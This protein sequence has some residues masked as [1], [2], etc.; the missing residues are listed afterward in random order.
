MTGPQAGD[1]RGWFAQFAAGADVPQA[2]RADLDR[3]AAAAIAAITELRD[4]LAAD[5][6]PRTDGQ[7]DG[8][9][10]ERYRV[11]AR[12]YTGADLD[13]ADAYAYG[14]SQYRELSASMLSEARKIVPERRRGA[15][16]VRVPRR[17]MARPSKESSRSATGCS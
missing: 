3:A 16:G 1:G 8:V 12:S 11:C 9:G 4:W 14:W 7:P 10:A 5:Y 13:L 2:L 6:L 17:R 15:G